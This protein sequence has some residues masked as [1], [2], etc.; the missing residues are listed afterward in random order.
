MDG[1]EFMSTSDGEM[2]LGVVGLRVCE[3]DCGSVDEES[4]YGTGGGK[5]SL[6]CAN[7]EVMTRVA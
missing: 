4:G 6:K 5:S 2:L 3:E 7:D 1:L